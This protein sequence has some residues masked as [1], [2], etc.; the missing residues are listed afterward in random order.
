M[1]PFAWTANRRMPA[2]VAPLNAGQD[3]EIGTSLDLADG[4]QNLGRPPSRNQ[5]H[6]LPLVSVQNLVYG[7]THLSRREAYKLAR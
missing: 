7:A 3:R 6:Q 2:R 4:L 1:I 5:S